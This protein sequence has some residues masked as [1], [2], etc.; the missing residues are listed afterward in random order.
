MIAKG[1]RVPAGP[2]DLVTVGEMLKFLRR[3]ARLT[4]RQLGLA[5]GYTEGHIC[6]LELNQRPPDV[7]TIAALFVPALGLD[8]EPELAAR[9]LELAAGQRPVRQH[10]ADPQPDAAPDSPAIPAPPAQ[11]VARTGVLDGLRALLAEER[12]VAICGLAGM[13]K[14]SVAAVLAR[15]AQADSPVCWITV[16]QGVTASADAL[17]RRL[18]WFLHSRDHVEARRLLQHRGGDGAVPLDEQMGL[19][20]AAL[21]RQPVFVCLDNVHLLVPDTVA[22]AV[23]AHLVATTPTRML[24]T[25]RADV[26]LAGVGVYRLAG[27][28]AGEARALVTA[29]DPALPAELAGRLITRTAGSPMLLR[30][31]LG[32]LRDGRGDPV[33]LV[34]RLEN[35]P[36]MTSYLLETTLNGLPPA[37]WRVLSLLAVFR[38]PVD[39]RD[40]HLVELS[41][42]CDGPYDLSA[43]LDELQRR[44]LVDHAAAATLHPLVHD[45]VYARMVSDLPRRR[46]LHRVA[47][48]WS[49]QA[50]DV[51]EAG[52]HF[53]QAGEVS[54]AADL[55]TAHSGDLVGRGQA[56]AAADLAESLLTARQVA[57]EVRVDLL[58]VRGDLLANTVRVADAEAAYRQAMAAAEGPRRTGIAARLAQILIQ[59]GDAGEAVRLC[60]EAVATVEATDRLQLAQL[61]ATTSQA[62][63][64]LSNYDEAID[65]AE[66]ALELAGRAVGAPAQAV[67]EVQARARLA[68]GQ[69]TRIRRRLDAAV[70]H[71]LH[72]VDAAG[73]AGRPGLV[74]QARHLLAVV[75][76]EQGEMDAAASLF[77]EVLASFRQLG[78]GYGAARVL[79]ALTQVFL[80]QSALDRA[81]E[82]TTQAGEI[83]T[84]LGDLPGVANAN[85]VRAEVLLAH[86][87]V[88]EARDLIEEVVAVSAKVS[89]TRERGYHLAVLAQTQ[90]VAGNAAV[91]ISALRT[92]IA[93]PDIAGTALCLLLHEYLAFA[94]LLAGEVDAAER[95]LERPD[96]ERAIGAEVPPGIRLDAYA[97]EVA[98]ALA[99]DDRTAAAKWVATLAQ[100]A[101][102][103]GRIRYQEVAG[104]LATAVAAAAGPAEVP[105]LIWGA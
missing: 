21:N 35:E 2:P 37:A 38:R 95:I 68:L 64:R 47:A 5:V 105:R 63:N 33:F 18:A 100:Y 20:G 13:G 57:D 69:A 19:L 81:L 97:V 52:Y 58:T 31:A 10:G 66:R 11:A 93:L 56:L 77:T 80:N 49:E 88:D 23:L 24:M 82:T 51:L 39:L 22:M 43:A 26:P 99:H 104:R 16:T 53:A 48:L 14:T 61:G 15:E 65:E 78:D 96:T 32:Q 85:C 79:L 40:E 102:A 59:C 60:R 29:T 46:R 101:G 75:Y 42:E 84:R 86:G 25:S 4:Q 12:R 3:R 87:R 45:Q 91:A 71:L 92:G 9:L 67:A 34:E 17:V 54:R 94:L 70:E 8:R 83:R 90:L 72:A 98:R 41:Q 1:S 74:S 73:R 89:S 7:A 28:E 50:R 6:R 44:L 103:T 36:Q 76:F 62:Q 55:L 30:L 27:L